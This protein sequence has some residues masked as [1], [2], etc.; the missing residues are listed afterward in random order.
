VGVCVYS[1]PFHSH[2]H[3]L[4]SNYCTVTAF[5]SAERKSREIGRGVVFL[6][7]NFILAPFVACHCI[8]FT[9]LPP[10]TFNFINCLSCV[11]VCACVC[12]CECYLCVSVRARFLL[13]KTNARLQHLSSWDKSRCWPP[14]SVFY[15]GVKRSSSTVN[16]KK[17][18]QTNN[19]KQTPNQKKKKTTTI[20]I[21]K[22]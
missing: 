1:F 2:T 7:A 22:K 17:E 11:C 16:R 9:C 15:T 8:S 12:V 19:K 18:I 3:L 14:Q 4:L 21:T 6:S 20:K 13:G 5:Q 10:K